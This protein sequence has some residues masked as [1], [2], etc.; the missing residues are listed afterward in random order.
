[1]DANT[2]I[3]ISSIITPVTVMTATIVVA[4]LQAKT[5]DNVN[6]GNLATNQV[7]DEVKTGNG[8][9][10]ARLADLTEGRRV[11]ADVPPDERTPHEA[12]AASM[13][14]EPDQQNPEVH[15]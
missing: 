8:R 12:H 2:I 7:H 14:N 1:V 11:V 4:R 15:P 6:L 10:I 5:N 3:A 13:L 9:T